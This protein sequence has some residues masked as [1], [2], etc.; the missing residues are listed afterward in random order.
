MSK[1]D[2]KTVKPEWTHGD[3]INHCMYLHRD[4]ENALFDMT[5]VDIEFDKSIIEH[6][7]KTPN[8]LTTEEISKMITDLS[9][10]LKAMYATGKAD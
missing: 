3:C 1:L 10:I 8:R 2:R 7:D 6:G 9:A 5:L 4:P